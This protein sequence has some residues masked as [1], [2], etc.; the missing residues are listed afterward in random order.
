MPTVTLA[1]VS[2]KEEALAQFLAD[3]LPSG[4]WG[5][6]D[7]LR[8]L[9]ARAM[10]YILKALDKD[11]DSI[12]TLL[13]RDGLLASDL[14]TDQ[15][16]ID[17]AS[18]FLRDLAIETGDGSYAQG[19]IVFYMTQ[20]QNIAVPIGTKATIGTVGFTT[21]YTEQ[22]SIPVE[23]LVVI[24]D[25]RGQAV[26][27]SFALSFVCDEPGEEGNVEA[28]PVTNFDNFNSFV[29][30]A[31]V[32]RD[33]EGGV[34]GTT[35]ED[36]L[37]NLPQYVGATILDNE[38]N[39]T[40]LLRQN[41]PYIGGIDVIE[42]G[43][44]LMSRD[45]IFGAN[46]ALRFHTTGK[47]DVYITTSVVQGLLVDGRKVGTEMSLNALSPAPQHTVRF[48]RDLTLDFIAEGVLVG[49]ILYLRDNWSGSQ[50]QYVIEKVWQHYL[51]VKAETP[52]P[53]AA[54]GI[55]YSIG[56]RGT[57]Y[58]DV[59]PGIGSTAYPTLGETT[60]SIQVP[61]AILMS[62]IPFVYI[63]DVSY[64][65]PSS[66]YADPT[67]GRVHFKRRVNGTPADPDTVDQL[68]YRIERL[69]P[70]YA[71]SN[72][73]LV[74]LHVGD[75]AAFAGQALA[76][77][78]ATIYGYGTAQE[79]FFGPEVQNKTIK[80]DILLRQKHGV[81]I[82]LTVRYVRNKNASAENV[83]KED[84]LL[85]YIAKTLT[86]ATDNEQFGLDDLSPSAR[87]AF[88]G[89]RSL[90]IDEAKSV[91]DMPDGTVLQ[92]NG[93]VYDFD[94]SIPEVRF[95][96]DELPSP[97][98]LPSEWGVGRKTVQFYCTPDIITASEETTE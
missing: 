30:A 24:R 81:Q 38:N 79:Q 89:L 93:F 97:Q 49:D 58:Q 17:A 96:A 75:Y 31:Q 70:H 20:A 77:T 46:P 88:P 18:A 27:Y 91:I 34:E 40:A 15:N 71:G 29:Y 84:D 56:R 67:T 60:A 35:Q 59:I 6:N 39:I 1:E 28:G 14:D 73:S 12:L 92:F 86:Q 83:F 43:N 76:V 10:G 61:G 54:D 85:N 52:F 33:F 48:F 87:A 44:S 3:H 25:N 5:R 95:P 64:R 90:Y 47:A 7:A 45:R 22:H 16:A 50:Y 41:A 37:T 13:S 68:E 57:D 8:H 82:P 53:V 11:R 66:P 62:A 19:S 32:I 63:E 78:A 23:D 98:L 65:D 69:R 4:K 21:T 36:V 42:A 80:G 55:T 2:N 9:A 26:G 94:S 51:M 74:L 72:E